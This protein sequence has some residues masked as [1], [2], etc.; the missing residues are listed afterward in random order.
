MK[1]FL[2]LLDAYTTSAPSSNSAGLS[3]LDSEDSLEGHASLSIS[4][5]CAQ[6]DLVL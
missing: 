4:S 6:L 1:I 3:K 5:S 2:Y